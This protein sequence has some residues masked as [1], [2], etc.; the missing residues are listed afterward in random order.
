VTVDDREYL[1]DI[2]DTAGQEDFSAVRDQYMVCQRIHARL[3]CHCNQCVLV[4]VM[5]SSL[6][7]EFLFAASLSLSISLAV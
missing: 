1:L 2:F 3:L 7:S 4:V 6:S 5:L